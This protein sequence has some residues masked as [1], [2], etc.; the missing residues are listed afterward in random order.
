MT[1]RGAAFGEHLTEK[2]SLFLTRAGWAK[3][4]FDTLEGLSPGGGVEAKRQHLEP[5]GEDKGGEQNHKGSPTP[6]DPK[7]SAD[8]GK[9]SPCQ[10]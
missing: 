10:R 1:L 5:Q 6:D 8:C 4:A 7:G 2:G 3:K 9:M